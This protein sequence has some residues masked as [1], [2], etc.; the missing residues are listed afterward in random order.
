MANINLR[1]WREERRKQRARE[2]ILMMIGALVFAG[3]LAFGWLSYMD[4]QINA[5]KARNNYLDQQ[6]AILDQKIVKIRE[7]QDQLQA[8][9]QRV[10]V[11]Q[12]LEAERTLIVQSFDELVEA[13]PEDVYLTSFRLQGN[14]YTL[15]GRA[16]SAPNIS[17]FIR[18][19]E[20]QATLFDSVAL[21]ESSAELDA[22]GAEVGRV[23]VMEAKRVN[24]AAQE[25]E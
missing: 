13:I 19:L 4:S 6:I 2:M 23:F 15:N 21:P 25:E 9:I 24:P 7:L 5:Q 20:R 12:S 17:A 14:T 18:N 1:P 22:Q 11:I 10:E 3:A 8:L 16:A